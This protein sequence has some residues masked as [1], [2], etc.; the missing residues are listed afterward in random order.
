MHNTIKITIDEIK[1]DTDKFD[2]N[3]RNYIINPI[4]LLQI[5]V[6]YGVDI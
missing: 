6:K 5:Q 4:V 2:E 3:S 1:H